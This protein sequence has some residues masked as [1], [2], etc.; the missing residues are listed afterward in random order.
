MED[1]KHRA[2]VGFQEAFSFQGIN[3]FYNSITKSSK[4]LSEKQIEMLPR[5]IFR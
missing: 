1:V 4:K 2:V 3:I 5:T